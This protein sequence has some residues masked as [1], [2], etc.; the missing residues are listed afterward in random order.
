MN[1]LRGLEA[2][3]RV[4]LQNG[5]SMVEV[6]KEIELAIDVGMANPDPKIQAH[7]AK[8]LRKGRKPTPEEVIIYLAEHRNHQ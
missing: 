5:V 1:K 3:R 4:A 6:R 7:W 2:I 8:I